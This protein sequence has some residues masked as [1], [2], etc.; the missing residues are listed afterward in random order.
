MRNKSIRDIVLVSGVKC[1]GMASSFVGTVVLA[2]ILKPL[3]FSIFSV[4]LG[5][6]T[7]GFVFAGHALDIG[8]VRFAAPLVTEDKT[9]ACAVFKSAFCIKLVL[10]ILLLLVGFLLRKKVSAILFQ[11]EHMSTAVVLTFVAV[12]CI[13]MARQCQA[14]LQ[15]T[16]L[17]RRYSLV[18]LILN[19][20]RLLLICAL[21]VFGISSVDV[22]LAAYV[23]GGFV[24]WI[25]AMWF[26]P[27]N[28]LAVKGDF[29]NSAVKLV[30]FSK[31]TLTSNVLVI[32]YTRLDVV[33]LG[34]FG[35][36]I[37][38]GRYNVAFSLAISLET[39]AASVSTVLFPR[40]S[41]FRTRKQ[42]TEYAKK[43]MK[44]GSILV[45]LALVVG[46]FA[47]PLIVPVFGSDYVE[48][49]ELFRVLYGGFLMALVVYPMVIVLF[50]LN[51]PHYLTVLDGCILLLSFAGN[52]LLI[53]LYGAW[54]AAWVTL[55]T[56]IVIAVVVLSTLFVKITRMPE[57]I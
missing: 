23:S 17:F 16:Q 12:L 18:E 33:L 25:F 5:I 37:E 11:A 48:S 19:I 47:A 39:I 26:L 29:W 46:F 13:S 6:M 2:R 52:I 15:A 30:R 22:S 36:T 54:G 35:K 44:Y 7:V 8:T 34:F 55:A 14:V 32:L 24:A 51:L 1:L 31:W 28:F 9:K 57:T 10:G 42:Y 4:C 20:T 27:V 50:S 56:K 41:S 3:D 21:L 43:V 38:A 53:P 45:T 49:I 40:V